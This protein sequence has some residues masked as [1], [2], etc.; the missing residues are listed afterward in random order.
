MLPTLTGNGWWIARP[1]ELPGSRPLAFEAGADAGAGA[2][3]PGRPSTSPSAWSATTPT[4]R[5]RCATRSSRSCATLQRACIGTGHELLVEVIPPREMRAR[6]PTRWR[7]RWRRSTPPASAP[8]GGSCRRR[9]SDARVA[10]RSPRSIARARSALPRRAAARPRG[11][12]GRRWR[13]SFRDR[14]AA[15]RSARASPSAA[16][17]SPTPRPPGS[18]AASS[19]ADVVADVAARYARLIA[20]LARGARRRR[21]RHPHPA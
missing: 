3:Q 17:S 10:A 5:R 21:R 12:R 19:D 11:E 14:R 8:T 15:R 7:A 9:D 16:R 1:V 13:A 2:A 20:L 18:P 6:R 4:T